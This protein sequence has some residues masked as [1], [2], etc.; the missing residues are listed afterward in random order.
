MNQH[1]NAVQATAELLQHEQY[2]AAE[3]IKSSAATAQ[4]RV[5]ECSANSAQNKGRIRYEHAR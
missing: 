5:S 2:I 1:Q 3:I 4:R